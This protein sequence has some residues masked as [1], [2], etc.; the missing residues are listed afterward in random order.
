MTVST[1]IVP[2]RTAEPGDL[3]AGLVARGTRVHVARV[4]HRYG[5]LRLFVH[6]VALCG[7]RGRLEPG[8]ITADGVCAACHRGA[9][10]LG[11]EI[12]S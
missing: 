2:T 8:R 3:V 12:P 6:A 7:R 9:D 10:K 4:D 11:I 5:P 1:V